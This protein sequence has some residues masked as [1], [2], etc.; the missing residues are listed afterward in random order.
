MNRRAGRLAAVAGIAA[1]GAIALNITRVGATSPPTSGYTVSS[2]P[3]TA[4][5]NASVLG[6]VEYID[7]QQNVNGSFGNSGTGDVPETAAAIVAYGTLAKN[8]I[9]NLPTA[10]TDPACAGTRDFRTDMTNAVTWMLGQQNA[11]APSSEGAGGAWDFGG[12]TT[13]ATGL[14]LTALS[15]SSTVPTTP[16]TAVATAITN[17]RAFLSN[18]F[19]AAPNGACSTVWVASG[20]TSY[21]CGGWNYD[22]S[23]GN[24]SDESN[25]GFAM[26]GLALTGGMPPAMQLVNVGW[27]ANV[28]ANTLTNP[29]WAA[30][31]NDGGGSYEPSLVDG[32]VPSFSSNSNDSGSLTF[33]FADDGLTA[34]DPRVQ[35]A[36]QFNTD[37]LDTLEKA[38]HSSVS[39]KHIMV[40]HTGATEDGSCDPSAGG[41][42]WGL[43][44]GEGGFHYSMFALSKGLGAFIAPKLSDGTNWY[45]KI[46][47]LLTTTQNTTA[48]ASFG[49]WPADLRDDFTPLFATALSVFSLGLVGVKVPPTPTPSPTPVTPTVP[50]TGVGP[51]SSNT[52]AKAAMV[53]GA[54]ALVAALLAPRSRRRGKSRDGEASR[55]VP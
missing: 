34:A 44:T 29:H 6:G 48:G 5:V 47:D 50:P 30:T 9:A 12:D 40:F 8:D 46:A 41:C 10:Q 4:Q 11:T 21:F 31:R 22:A 16:P 45:S 35:V 14:A 15:F 25:T 32:G 51:G 13:Y 19:Q 7:C 20:D 55:L 42:D 49:S 43:G 38:A 36:L 1:I 26:T 23:F 27:Q 24:H 53:L 17:G 18:D 54:V 28:Q 39:V 2:P 37:A 52:G 3:T 33:G